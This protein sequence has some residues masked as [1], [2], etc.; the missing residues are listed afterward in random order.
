MYSS[1][2]NAREIGPTKLGPKKLVGNVPKGAAGAPLESTGQWNV[3][4]P[5]DGLGDEFTLGEGDVEGKILGVGLGDGGRVADG[6][7]AGVAVGVGIGV[8]AGEG[9]G[10]EDGQKLSK[11]MSLPYSASVSPLVA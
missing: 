4:P 2:E 9:L 7:G 8:A 3:P 5:G 6:A 1:P 10:L 11:T